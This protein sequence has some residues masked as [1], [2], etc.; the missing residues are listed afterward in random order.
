MASSDA[1]V[2]AFKQRYNLT[3]PGYRYG[4][5]AG[6]RKGVEVLL[7][8]LPAIIARYPNARV[9]FAWAI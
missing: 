1:D 6:R 7:S 3:L 5:A 9:L 8:A 4:S 2:E